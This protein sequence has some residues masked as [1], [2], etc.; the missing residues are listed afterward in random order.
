MIR[1][2]VGL[3]R[4]H[5]LASKAFFRKLVIFDENSIKIYLSVMYKNCGNKL[6]LLLPCGQILGFR[7]NF[8]LQVKK[9]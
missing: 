3:F 4:N 8:R 1:E 5:N 6:F 7:Q 2:L 9:I